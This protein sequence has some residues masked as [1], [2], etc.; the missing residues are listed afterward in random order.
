MSA[1]RR[2]VAGRGLGELLR[3]HASVDAQAERQIHALASDSRRVRPGTL[4]FARPGARVDGADF[5]DA[6]LAA[7]A[8]AVVR[9]GVP[10]VT[11]LDAGG[12]EVRVADI[13]ACMADAARRFHDDPSAAIPVVGVTGTNGKTS[14]SHFIAAVLHRPGDT[15]CGLLGTLGAGLFGALEAGLHTTPDVLDVQQS[16]A[17][18]RDAGAAWAVMEVSSH[19]LEQGRVRGVRFETAVFTNLSRDHLDYHGDMDAYGRAKQR[20]FEL[21]HLRHAVVNLD[22]AHGR[23]LAANVATGVT[24]LG[25]SLEAGVQAAVR[26]RILALGADG[27]HLAV[28]TPWGAGEIRSRLAG[29]FNAAN[30]LAAVA[31]LG[32]LDV[33]LERILEGLSRALPPP[34]R[35][36][37]LGGGAQPLVV[38]DYAH[39]PDALETV[40]ATLRPQC[41]GRLWCVFGCGGERDRGKRPLMAQVAERLADRVVIT[42]DNPRGEDGDAIVADILAGTSRADVLVERDRAA[43]ITRAVTGAVAG[44]IVLVAGKGHEPYQ[45][46]DGHRTPFSDTAVVRNVLQ[47]IAGGGS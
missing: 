45:E 26:G 24:L 10:G 16:L 30:L 2:I 46:V 14:V 11:R 34:G 27:L 28:V 44:D 38:V 36:E 5:I 4:F 6:A 18:M 15:P 3:G 7:G 25:Y 17:A 31:A 20:L 23:T 37:C 9:Q 41:E 42:D 32:S 8:P 43:A 47:R 33:P 19:A 13:G 1:A 12:V 40:L 29:R 35:M 22:D 21:E 39:T